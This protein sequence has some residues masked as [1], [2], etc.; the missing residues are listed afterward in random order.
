MK[1]MKECSGMKK[2]VKLSDT[3]HLGQKNILLN[4]FFGPAVENKSS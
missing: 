3:S 2:M 1:G 4:S